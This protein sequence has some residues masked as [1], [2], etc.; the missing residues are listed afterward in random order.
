MEMGA[1]HKATSKG[2]ARLGCLR[3]QAGL[4]LVALTGLH[5][6]E[7][8]VTQCHGRGSASLSAENS[9]DRRDRGRIEDRGAPRRA[10]GGVLI[11][12]C[13]QDVSATDDKHLTATDGYELPRKTGAAAQ[14]TNA[15]AGQYVTT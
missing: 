5:V 10:A 2:S 15:A 3:P 7:T 8:D 13:R 6:M 12:F 14:H 1:V 9:L 11:G 4:V